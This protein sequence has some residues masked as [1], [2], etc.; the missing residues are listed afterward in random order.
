M[1]FYGISIV[2]YGKVLTSENNRKNKKCI[3]FEW[4]IVE[5]SFKLHCTQITIGFLK[6]YNLRW[7]SWIWGS[8]LFVYY[9]D[10][11]DMQHMYGISP[12]LWY[13]AFNVNAYASVLYWVKRLWLTAGNV[14]AGQTY[15]KGTG[16][17]DRRD[18]FFV[19]ANYSAIF[20][21][22]FKLKPSPALQRVMHYYWCWSF[23]WHS[24]LYRGFS[25]FNCIYIRLV[26]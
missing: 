1:R 15:L 16:G 6:I 24:S 13:Q 12:L 17:R 8:S 7:F 19:I 5:F 4:I 9:N 10:V 2:S 21:V 25:T 14:W 23:L 20:A 3:T 22:C 18:R 11:I 26:T